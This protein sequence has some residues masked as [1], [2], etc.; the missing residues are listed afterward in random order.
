M[1]DDIYKGKRVLVTGHQGFCGS[2]LALWLE[3]LG[4]NVIGFGRQARTE[5]NHHNLLHRTRNPYN[6]M[7]TI[8]DLRG[9]LD[10]SKTLQY[11]QPDLII[12]LAAKAIVAKTFEEPRETFDNNIM[13]AVNLL[14]AIRQHK[15]AKGVVFVT[16]DKVYR[17]FNWQ[18]GYRETDKLG[19]DDP[20][21]VSKIC[22]EH[23][24][25]CY[26]ENYG[27]SIAVARAGNVIGGGDWSYKRLIPDI[28]KA[29]SQLG[30]V[31]IHTPTA[32]R[33]W[34]H[35]LE[36]L[37]GYLLLGKAILEGRQDINGAYNFGPERDLTVLNI[38]EIARDIWS[39]IRWDID[40]EPTHPHMVYSLRLDSTK[41]IRELDWHPV[42]S[43]ERTVEETILWYREYYE[44]NLILSTKNI[45]DFEQDI[46]G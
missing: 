28:V 20:Y 31:T 29:A 39:N 23:I 21:S 7:S 37:N 19:G 46:G 42:W 40:N 16:T 26:R 5:P 30:V 38:L 14:D 33:P 13:G 34:Q 3:K 22:L 4:A 2:W 44:R 11:Y 43:I 18:W 36:A 32:T 9:S 1:Y 6:S 12:H 35:V 25:N 15:C 10:V 8:R 17:D 41:A 27:M 45:I 24:I